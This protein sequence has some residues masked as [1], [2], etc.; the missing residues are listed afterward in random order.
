MGFCYLGST[1][2]YFPKFLHCTLFHEGNPPL[3][4]GVIVFLSLRPVLPERRIHRCLGTWVG[5]L[6]LAWHNS[7]HRGLP[8]LS[9]EGPLEDTEG[10][11]QVPGNH[12][13]T[14]TRH[15]PRETSLGLGPPS[16][17]AVCLGLHQV[18][19]WD[20]EVLLYRPWPV[21]AKVQATVCLTQ[22]RGQDE[23]LDKWQR[24]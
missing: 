18:T 4:L 16:G 21:N 13:C 12:F 11:C 15:A 9:Q 22:S 10:Q 14:T 24:L 20:P 3:S 7:Q 8:W 2:L 17:L 1:Y 5:I 23:L 6:H 19:L